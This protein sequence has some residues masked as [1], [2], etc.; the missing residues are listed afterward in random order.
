MFSYVC[1][2]NGSLHKPVLTHESKLNAL[3]N[4]GR[5]NFQYTALSQYYDA[6]RKALFFFKEG[7][8]EM[9]EV[10]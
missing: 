6:R 9:Y 5:L 7:L 8:K 2:W 3:F 1:S 4:G 10:F